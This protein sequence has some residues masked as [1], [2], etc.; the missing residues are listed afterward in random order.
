M[1][2]IIKD[3]FRIDKKNLIIILLLNIGVALVN[4]ISIVMLIPML[5][6][7]NVSVGDDSSLNMLLKPFLEL[8]Y[9]GR[10]IAI[11]SIFIVLIIAR[12]VL[13]S[14][15]TIKQAKFFEKYEVCLRE[16]LYN[17][18]SGAEWE[19]LSKK[20]SP[21]LINLFSIQCRQAKQCLTL[22]VSFATSIFNAA[23]QLIIAVS[24]SLPISLV[25]F[26]VGCG[27]LV[28]FRPFLKKSKMFGKTFVEIFHELHRE[29]QNQ[30]S[31][32][33]EIRAYD[34]EDYHKDIFSKTSQKYY[35]TSIKAVKIRVIPN[36]LYSI[37]GAVIVALS[38]VIS[39][40]VMKTGTV[41]IVI[42][43]YVFSRLWPIFTSWQGQL[44]NIQTALPSYEKIMEAIDELSAKD[45]EEIKKSEKITFTKEVAFEKIGFKY[46][47]S[48][49]AVLKDIDFTLPCGTVT[50]LVGPSGVGKSTTADLILG[51]LRPTCG[52]ITVDGKELCSENIASWRKSIGYIPQEPLILNASIRENL[53]RFHPNSTDEEMIEAL[54]KSN[55]W[56]FVEKLPE[57]LD[58][59]LGDKGVRLSGGERQRIVLAR[60]LMGSPKLIILDEATS[61]LDFESENAIRETIRSLR[62]NSTV[63]VIAHRLATIKGADRAVVLE[64]GTVKESGSMEELLNKENGYLSRMISVE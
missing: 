43:V 48:E 16:K 7:L 12:A 35:D 21:D 11:I 62:G 1:K 53:K 14:F 57:G 49:E 29:V 50:A 28:I 33:K 24:M 13:N 6:L 26:T 15:S 55:G 38:F 22:S 47:D 61:A 25:I 10:A 34:V 30:F 52:R 40:L 3:A 54:K 51:L 56:K 8:S 60:V 44:Q 5:D 9:T 20:S 32:I 36:L 18:I 64:G 2:Q 42:L 59:N 63:V 19:A 37:A 46:K 23:L 45:N 17:A 31:S 58:T 41:Q 39:V 27:F 4:S